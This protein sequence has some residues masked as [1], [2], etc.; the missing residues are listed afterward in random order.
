MQGQNCLSVLS[1]NPL[2]YPLADSQPATLEVEYRGFRGIQHV[3]T[4]LVSQLMV[5]APTVGKSLF[6]IFNGPG[7]GKVVTVSKKLGDSVK[8]V[9]VGQNKKQSG[10]IVKPENICLVNKID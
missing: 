7:K 3:E 6:A 8:V 2:T 9:I 10:F 1:D 4:V 5:R